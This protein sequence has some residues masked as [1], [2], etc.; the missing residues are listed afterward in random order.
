MQQLRPREKEGEEEEMGEAEE[1]GRED[2]VMMWGQ[3]KG[4]GK[5][6]CLKK[7]GWKNMSVLYSGLYKWCF[8]GPL[9]I[10]LSAL[11][12]LTDLDLTQW[13]T[14]KCSFHLSCFVWECLGTPTGRK[15]KTQKKN[16]D[17]FFAYWIMTIT[18]DSRQLQLPPEKETD[19]HLTCW[20]TQQ[21]RLMKSSLVINDASEGE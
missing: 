11:F 15:K 16:E 8:P 18:T 13:R 10:L 20:A 14:N 12:K 4:K 3:R 9:R 21:G 6:W 1:G 5:K 7:G 19:D 17:T 2:W